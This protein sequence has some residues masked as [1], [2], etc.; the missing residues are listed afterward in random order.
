MLDI[1]AAQFTLEEQIQD[2]QLLLI[3]GLK[4]LQ[5]VAHIN[6]FAAIT[7]GV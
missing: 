1:A 3:N 6:T 5:G 7:R 4:D 2:A